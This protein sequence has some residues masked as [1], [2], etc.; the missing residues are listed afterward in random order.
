MNQNKQS[1]TTPEQNGVEQSTKGFPVVTPEDEANAASFEMK[2]RSSDGSWVAAVPVHVTDGGA[3]PAAQAEQ[4]ESEPA[5]PVEEIAAAEAAAAPENEPAAESAEETAPEQEAE[6]PQ[7]AEE[8]AQPEEKAQPDEE[9][10]PEPAAQPDEPEAA[11]E[12]DEQP[13]QPEAAASRRRMLRNRCIAAAAVGV[14]AVVG[15]FSAFVYGYGGIFPGVHVADE[16]KL[17]GMTQTEAQ[18]YIAEDV[19]NGIFDKEITL[20]GKDLGA[21]TDKEYTI[22]VADVAATIDSESSAQQAYLIGREGNYFQRVGT[23]LNSMFSGWEVSLNATVQDGAIAA[24]VAEIAADLNYDPVQPSWEVNKETAELTVDTGKE[25]L[26][27]DADKVVSDLTAKVQA[28]D[29]EGY[30]IETY[31][32]DQDKPDA[33]AI[34]ADVNCDPQNATVDKSD[35]VT[36]I[37][38]V[39]GVAVEESAIASAIGDAAEQTYTVPVEL[40][41]AKVKKADLEPVLFRDVLGSATTYYNSGQT[42]RTTNVRLSARACDGVILNPGEEFSYNDV[43]G[44][45]TAAR[46]YRSAIIFQ[47]GEEVEGLGGGVC[48]PS[49][50]IYMATLRADLEVSERYNHQFQVSYTPVSQ[51]AAVAWGSKDYKFINNTDYPVKL[52]V[53]VGGGALTVRIIGTKTVDKDISL[54]ARTYV[55]GKYKHA[56]LYK[57]VTINGE[58]TTNK[59]N[60]SAYLLR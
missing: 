1:G 42:S 25:G 8:T 10:E 23:V 2:K 45:R 44:E 30:T 49:S 19:Q 38:A 13:E 9:A 29:L 60:T 43:V 37:E 11:F 6:T 16:Y 56:T 15:G 54:Y 17:S 52:D 33:A 51:D 4:P 50:T 46:G 47:E 22:R 57:T 32:V 31:A 41:E 35:G 5:E 12:A 59:E 55:S 3:Q 14:V 48:Q 26:G 36:V 58:S 39:T 24:E 18:A 20:T 7:A 34:A 28:V 27:F 40:T 21:D 53:S